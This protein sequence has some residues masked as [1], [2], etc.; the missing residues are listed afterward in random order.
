MSDQE[1]IQL[2]VVETTQAAADAVRDLLRKGGQRVRC[3]CVQ[4]ESALQRQLKKDPPPG[5]ILCNVEVIALERAV[6]AAAASG[7]DIPVVALGAREDLASVTDALRAGARDLVT[8][9]NPQHLQL[10]MAREIAC[11]R[12]VQAGAYW[13]GA[14]HETERRCQALLEASSDAVAYVH[15]GM[16]IRANRAYL[17]LFGC[18]EEEIGGTPVMDMVDRSD[19]PKLK[20]FL[21]QYGRRAEAGAAI[22]VVALRGDGRFCARLEFTPA[23]LDGEPC[24]QVVVRQLAAND[25]TEEAQAPTEATPGDAG[26]APPEVPA[27]TEAVHSPVL[28]EPPEPAEEAAQS[29]TPDEEQEGLRQSIREVLGRDRL[30]FAYQTV[31]QLDGSPSGCYGVALHMPKA[32]G[33]LQATE[34]VAKAERVGMRREIDRWVLRQA[35]G[36][37]AKQH[38]R[39][40]TVR[41]LVPVSMTTLADPALAPSLIAGMKAAALPLECLVP[42]VPLGELLAHLQGRLKIL[43][44]LAKVGIALALDEVGGEP[45]LLEQATTIPARYWRLSEKLCQRLAEREAQQAQMKLVAEQARAIDVRTIAPR[46]EDARSMV[47]LWRLGIDYAEGE[48]LRA[49]EADL[50][51]CF[52]AT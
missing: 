23:S 38:Q 34:L 42:T 6:K 43:Q 15:E 32:H 36:A 11:V 10:V 17:T 22:E 3:T 9:R 51:A 44:A 16:H 37:I 8:R 13:E 21:R 39:K 48:F 2:L 1:P 28:A 49:P 41:L 30:G 4:D 19:H 33:A 46:I 45:A 12:R 20:A 50:D 29:D 26:T 35:I 7:R 47:V 18:D 14:Y 5:V 25:A 40:R 52:V 24:T 31:V 27:P